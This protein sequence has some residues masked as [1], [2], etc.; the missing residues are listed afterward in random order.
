ML[1]KWDR[2][3]FQGPFRLPGALEGLD[4]HIVPYTMHLLIYI[5]INVHVSL[6]SYVQRA[7]LRH[8]TGKGIFS[9]GQLGLRR[10][11]VHSLRPFG[12]G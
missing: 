7:R 8:G 4:F 1:P 9:R 3:R 2:W 11:F 10:D 5:Y 6:Y 12:G